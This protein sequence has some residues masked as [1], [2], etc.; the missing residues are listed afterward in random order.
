MTNLAAKAARW[1]VSPSQIKTFRDC[2]RKWGFSYIDGIKTPSTPAAFFGSV[3]H[4]LL[5]EHY[6]TGTMRGGSQFAQLS[7]EKQKH[8]MQ[9]AASALPHYPHYEHDMLTEQSFTFE[10]GDVT[11]RGIVDLVHGGDLWTPFHHEKTPD[12]VIND[13]KT[14]R[15]PEKWGLDAISLPTDE[16]FLIYAAWASIE[17]D[18]KVVGGQWTYL[19]TQGKTLGIPVRTVVDSDHIRRHLE[20]IVETGQR[21]LQVLSNTTTGNDLEPTVAS[22]GNYG[23]CPY[24]QLGVCVLTRA[25]K[26]D[27]IFEQDKG[28]MQ[29]PTLAEMLAKK[30]AKPPKP[31]ELRVVETE[32]SRSI[33]TPEVPKDPETKLEISKSIG[34]SSKM[35]GTR[36]EK[37]ER[38]R[39]IV[40]A[41]IDEKDTKAVVEDAEKAA[42]ARKSATKDEIMQWVCSGEHNHF[43]SVS[44]DATPEIPFVHGRTLSAMKRK[45]LVNYQKDGPIY[46]VTPTDA[47]K[48]TQPGPWVTAHPGPSAVASEAKT[49]DPRHGEAPTPLEDTEMRDVWMELAR[50][51]DGDPEKTEA[52]FAAF[53]KRFG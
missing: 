40:E 45:G 11:W 20:P 48:A 28:T 49:S 46:N 2:E 53:E 1:R 18:V 43:H 12:L 29:M 51:T 25:E 30:K 7:D 19:K 50:L 5:E 6:K 39:A 14:S 41:A 13:H 37:A 32:A 16:Q 9:V 23:G 44:K 17:H 47:G 36:D 38:E 10:Y 26:L 42:A 3:V 8:A 4:E 27:Q 34:E 52:L 31:S 33:N 15:D 24:A 22:C 35:G 21:I